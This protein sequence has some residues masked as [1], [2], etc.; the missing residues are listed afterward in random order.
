MA[1]NMESN[2]EIND[3]QSLAEKKGASLF[4]IIQKII[5]RHPIMFIIL[6]WLLFVV[7]PIGN[8]GLWAPDEPRYLQVAW[9]MTH[10]G[11]YLV[12]I[13]NGEIYAE[14]PPLFFWLTMVA[15]KIFAFETASRWV[16]AFASLG[17]LLLTFR[18]G[19]MSKDEKTG[20]T[21]VLVLMS[22]SLFTLLMTTG[23][24]DITLTFFTT[25][26]LFFFLKWDGRQEKK[27]LVLA[28]GACGLGILAKGPVALL[29]PWLSFVLWESGKYFRHE[30]AS[31]A[32]LAWG[33][34]VALAIAALW[35]IPACIA[36][37]REYTRT[38]LFRQQFGRVIRSAPHSRPVFYYFLNF[39]L[40]AL[41]WF[42]V[43]AGVA[44]VIKNAVRDRQR[45]LLFFG[46]WICTILVFFSLPSGKRERYLL[47]LYPAFSIIIAHIVARWSRRRDTTLWLRICAILVLVILG[48]LMLFPAVVPILKD[49][50][51]VLSIFPFDLA[52][53]HLWGIYIPGVL[54]VGLIRQAFKHL[55]VRQHRVACN[56]V[57]VS[58]LLGFAIVQLYYIP[59]VDRV[60][61][62]RYASQTIRSILPAG[63][64]VAFYGR[65]FDNG[66][67]F[68]LQRAKI[69]VITDEQISHHPPHYDLII[70]RKKDLPKLKKVMPLTRYEIAA[71]QPVGSKKFVL[72]KLKSA[73]QAARCTPDKRPSI[74]DGSITVNA[75]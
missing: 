69:P 42:I 46:L 39:P 15:A 51:S 29:V 10:T 61:S 60:K 37:G 8:R 58:L 38:I 71:V 65:R 56:L 67:N 2:Q 28:Y 3:V 44:P 41:P 19:V 66:W 72:L 47:P 68:Y 45:E 55:H 14:K 48:V 4:T 35:V 50:F 75:T 30:K 27:F 18:L 9:E 59:H 21:A 33:P 25:A 52:D 5:S 36:G 6:L 16:S 24:I 57:A 73:G 70:L 43:L 1:A 34:A 40:D 17:I 11:S 12:P 7:L 49:R 63:G 13:M 22:T 53:W 20:L 62:A 31:F 32:H 26:S 74:F 64:S 54:A 23:N